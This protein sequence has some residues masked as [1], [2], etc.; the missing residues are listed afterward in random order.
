MNRRTDFDGE[1]STDANQ[2]I[3]L[4]GSGIRRLDRFFQKEFTV[5]FLGCSLPCCAS[6]FLGRKRPKVNFP[7]APLHASAPSIELWLICDAP[8]ARSAQRQRAIKVVLGV[9]RLAQIARA[10]FQRV[11]VFVVD[12]FWDVIDVYAVMQRVNH[13]MNEHALPVQLNDRSCAPFISLYR[14]RY[15]PCPASIERSHRT[16]RG[17]VVFRPHFPNQNTPIGI[18]A[19][20]LGEV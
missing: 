3:S 16:K 5:D 2:G 8:D 14:P 19:E 17:E 7:A 4:S 13:A 6:L 9:G 1:G 11:S 12:N 20:A 18:K 10:I 15:R